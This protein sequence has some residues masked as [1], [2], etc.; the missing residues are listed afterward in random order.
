M[1]TYF[2]NKMIFWD[3]AIPLLLLAIIAPFTPD[4]D[5]TFANYFFNQQTKQFSSHPFFVFMYK[6]GVLPGQMIGIAAIL[7]FLLSYFSQRFVS[8]R[9][10]ALVMIL[11]IGVGAGL[12]THVFFKDHW[13][14]PRPKQI[15]Q[16]GGT[17][18]FR[19]FYE[20]NFSAS[21]NFKSFPSGHSGIGFC[22]FALA[23]HGRRI[24]NVGLYRGGILIAL[25]LG[26]GLSLTRIAQG[27]HFFSDTLASACL[28]WMV[29]AISDWLLYRSSSKSDS[30]SGSKSS[31]VLDFLSDKTLIKDKVQATKR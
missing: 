15:E 22:F 6:W 29:A 2:T 30:G 24:H 1:T 20:P 14:R 10:P 26:I 28:I 19:A 18:S 21:G 25:T 17:E 16:F 3:I 8:W 13:K 9:K 11:T 27:G 31:N 12:I 7:V 5:L 23:I 4:L